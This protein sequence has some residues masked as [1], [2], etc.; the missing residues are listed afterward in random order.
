P[1]MPAQPPPSPR[2]ARRSKGF[3][4]PTHRKPR[5]RQDPRLC[6]ALVRRRIPSAMRPIADFV[7]DRARA[8]DA[9][10]IRKVFD[11]AAK[12]KDPINLSIGLPD[13][14]VPDPAKQAAVD[15]IWKGYNAYTPTQGIEPLRRKLREKLE[16]EIGAFEGRGWDVIV[17]GGVSGGLMLALMAM[18]ND[19]DE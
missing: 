15:A 18:V 2:A 1:R 6:H 10:G 5:V 13:F 8:I 9:S 7:S 11:L 14:D 4:Y 19:G 16:P 17:T 3:F 12:M